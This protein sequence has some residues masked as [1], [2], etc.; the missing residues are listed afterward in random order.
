MYIHTHKTHERWYKDKING[1]QVN[2]TQLKQ[3]YH[4]IAT[5]VD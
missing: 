5:S 4:H 2:M 3:A 1:N